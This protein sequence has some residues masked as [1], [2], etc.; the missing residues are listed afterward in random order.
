ME[1]RYAKENDDLLG[2]IGWVGANQIVAVKHRYV[3]LLNPIT[4]RLLDLDRASWRGRPGEPPYVLSVLTN[5]HPKYEVH[6]AGTP[7]HAY[8]L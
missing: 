5:A 4:M 6:A 1:L 8:L 7:P 3:G 2:A